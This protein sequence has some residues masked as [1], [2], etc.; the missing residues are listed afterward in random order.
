MSPV[1]GGGTLGGLE[2]NATLRQDVDPLQLEK[3]ELIEHHPRSLIYGK[4]S[5]PE[6]ESAQSITE[7]VTVPQI[8]EDA[9]LTSDL[10]YVKSDDDHDDTEH[11]DTEHVSFVTPPDTS[12]IQQNFVSNTTKSEPP[13]DCA[14]VLQTVI[15]PTN[16]FYDATDSESIIAQEEDPQQVSLSSYGLVCIHTNLGTLNKSSFGID[17]EKHRPYY[18]HEEKYHCILCGKAFSKV[19]SL[20][21]H[22]RCHTG[23]KPYCCIQCGRRF[24]HAGDFKKHKRVHTG[25]KPYRCTLCGKGFSQSGYL[26]IHQ[27]Y[28]TGERPYCCSQCG[29][30]FSQSSHLK[31]HQKIHFSQLS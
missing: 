16:S 8:V 18:K 23:E 31:K 24:S 11:C 14:T 26:K 4:I 30:S 13:A 28:H 29:K 1:S 20:R 6:H 7:S 2:S 19:G 15:Q 9:L 27:R 3:L 5:G 12:T 10:Q 17:I 21:I 25:E 22:Q